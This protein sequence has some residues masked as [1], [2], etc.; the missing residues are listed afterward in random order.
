MPAT[1]MD[2]K[3]AANGKLIS[4]E[5][6][7]DFISTQLR[8]LPP[9]QKI[10]ILPPLLEDL[11]EQ[12]GTGS[13]NARA[14]IRN[15]HTAF[16]ER[17]A[18]AHSFLQAATISQP[19]L[20]FMNGGAVAARSTCIL[21]ICENCTDGD[22]EGAEAIFDDIVK[23][24]VF[25][26]MQLNE[27]HVEDEEI[28]DTQTETDY[29]AHLEDSSEYDTARSTGTPES[30]GHKRISRQESTVQLRELLTHNREGIPN[31]RWRSSSQ[32]YTPRPRD[33]LFSTSD[34]VRT[35]IAIP[36]IDRN[37]LHAKR[38]T[39]ASSED[40]LPTPPTFP[41]L[42]GYQTYQS[43]V[44][45]EEL[46]HQLSSNS[47][48]YSATSTPQAV[49]F[50]EACIVDVQPTASNKLRRVVSVDHLL[51]GNLEPHGFILENKRLRHS[52]SDRH[53]RNWPQPIDRLESFPEF[54][55][56]QTTFLKASQMTI[57]KSPKMSLNLSP[58]ITRVRRMYV[59][60]GTDA[61]EENTQS[62]M[63]NEVA[64]F[65]PVFPVVEDLVI[66][67]NDG[68]SDPILDSVILSYKNGAYPK[69]PNKPTTEVEKPHGEDELELSSSNS[70][71]WPLKHE[72]DTIDT[73]LALPTPS[74]TPPP[75]STGCFDKFYAFSPFDVENAIEVQN[76]L[77]L[78]LGLYFPREENY[79]QFIFPVISEADRFWKP[80]FGSNEDIL[81]HGDSTIDHIIALG[82][83]E[84]VNQDLFSQISGQVEQLGMKRDG[85]NRSGR[86]DL[87]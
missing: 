78:V 42:L 30:L 44:D 81:A 51:P 1:T 53:L 9:S 41:K 72:A 66:Y 83:E 73:V 40:S 55:H 74:I 47:P 63:S 38:Y 39:I 62:Y 65:E 70:N 15:V 14:F 3:T 57:K 23:D 54:P 76:T 45:E 68:S 13:F 50:G 79:S 71:S 48:A 11:P 28:L 61:V 8:L 29:E 67:F 6:D 84:G 52:S 59:D 82:C 19:R 12:D 2:S 16:T 5:C 4:V 75:V 21:Q 34:I 31:G 10:L 18:T 37:T 64:P 22:I 49:I 60:R 77:R 36:E 86:L 56:P 20:A 27:L 7:A 32:P 85:T 35:L 46:D 43:E 58:S 26:L 17:V 24:G 69:L 87:R 80:V 25:G 33:I